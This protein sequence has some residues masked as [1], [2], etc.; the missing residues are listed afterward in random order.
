MFKHPFSIVGLLRILLK[1]SRNFVDTLI[2]G[3]L[4]LPLLVQLFIVGGDVAEPDVAGEEDLLVPAL[5]EGDQVADVTV[6]HVGLLRQH[7]RDEDV[8]HAEDPLVAVLEDLQQL[9]A[10]EVAHDVDHAPAVGR[11]ELVRPLVVRDH[12]NAEWSLTH[13]FF[14]NRYRFYV[15]IY[16]PI[17]LSWFQFSD[18]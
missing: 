8:V 3:T 9:V 4:T 10:D 16:S 17:Y 2:Q 7:P 18:G 1:S 15:C 12:L 11:E 5:V 13:V 6:A 14:N